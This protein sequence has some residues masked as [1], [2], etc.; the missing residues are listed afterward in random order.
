M[1]YSSTYRQSWLKSWIDI[2]HDV[3]HLRVEYGDFSHEWELPRGLVHDSE[4]MR[5]AYLHYNACIQKQKTLDEV[6]KRL[7]P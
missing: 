7:T 6:T 1:A 2:K 5:I 4:C 3:V